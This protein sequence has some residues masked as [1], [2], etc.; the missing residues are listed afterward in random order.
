MTFPAGLDKR[1]PMVVK[2]GAEF[3]IKIIESLKNTL[4]DVYVLPDT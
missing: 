1:V 3:P 4:F 2:A